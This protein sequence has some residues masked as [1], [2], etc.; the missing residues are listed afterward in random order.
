M[1]IYLIEVYYYTIDCI[2]PSAGTFFSKRIFDE[3]NFL[4]IKFKASMDYEFFCRLAS[5]NYKFSYIHDP[6][7]YFKKNR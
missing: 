5:L 6:I 1:I 2:I 3:K 4:D 7:A